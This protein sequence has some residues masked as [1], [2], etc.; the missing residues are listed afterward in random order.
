MSG[1][2]RRTDGGLFPGAVLR[3]PMYELQHCQFLGRRIR[4][5]LY[6][7]PGI[8][9][10]AFLLR[11]ANQREIRFDDSRLCAEVRVFL[12]PYVAP[13][14]REASAVAEIHEP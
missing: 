6:E 7:S 8:R 11:S 12:R 4:R 9:L 13:N 5:R 1:T 3:L 2:H 14:D 10:T